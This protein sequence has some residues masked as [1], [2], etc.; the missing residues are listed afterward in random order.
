TSELE[1]RPVEGLDPTVG[2]VTIDG[3]VA[4]VGVRPVD[5]AAA[6]RVARLA[7]AHEL[8]GAS[9]RMLELARQHALERIQFGVPIA[10]FQAVRHRLAETLVAIEMTEAALDGGWID[11]APHHVLIAKALAGRS[12]RVA[13]RHCQQVLAGIGFTM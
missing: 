3:R 12:A 2:L 10:S 9:R 8:L 5:W 1:N 13:S 11:A 6:V 4:L 7:L